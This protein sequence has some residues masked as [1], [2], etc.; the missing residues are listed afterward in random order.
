MSVDSETRQQLLELVYGAL[1]E[2]E[3]DRLRARIQDD[4]EVA[5]AYEEARSNAGLI[6]AAARISAPRVPLRRAERAGSSQLGSPAAAADSAPATRALPGR[7]GRHWT[8]MAYWTVGAASCVLLLLSLGGYLLHRQRLADIAA[9]H[10]R[11]MV[12]GPG[13]LQLG[14]EN[15]VDIS[16]T[17][18]TGQPMPAQ[19]ELALYSPDGEQLL[20]HKEKTDDDGKLTVT[21][22][23]EPP[24]PPSVRLEVLAVHRD[25]LQ[26]IDAQLATRPIDW[27]THVWTDRPRYRPGDTVFYRS[28]T[29]PR[30]TLRADRELPLAFE[31][32]APDGTVLPGSRNEGVTERGV[33]NGRFELPDSATPG[34]YRLYC[35]SLDD[36]APEARCGFRV[37][38]VRQPSLEAQIAFTQT[39]YRPGDTMVAQVAATD[40][41]GQPLAQQQLQVTV[42]VDRR[43]IDTQ[44]VTTDALGRTRIETHLPDEIGSGLGYVEIASPEASGEA[45]LP[46]RRR[47]PIELG[48][49]DVAFYPEGGNLVA[50]LENR[51]YFAAT[52][53]DGRPIEITGRVVDGEGNSIVGL[54]TT[55]HGRG[56]VTF[57]PRTGE[58]YRLEIDE[59]EHYRNSPK[60]P[61]VSSSQPALLTT[62]IGVFEPGK[63][64]AFNIRALETGLPLV[65]S[66]WCRGV[67]VGQS[68]LVSQEG[69]NSVVVELAD[70]AAGVVRLTV[71]DYSSSPPAPLSE[72]LI[73]RRPAR[74][75]QLDCEVPEAAVAGEALGLRVAALDEDGEGADAVFGVAVVDRGA[76]SHALK[77]PTL[78][79]AFLLPR[80]FD[81]S[82]LLD[83]TGMLLEESASSAVALDLLLGTSGWRRVEPAAAPSSQHL[84]AAS[85]STAT[86][87][88]RK[89]VASVQGETSPLVADNLGDIQAKYEK[90][91]ASYRHDRTRAFNA[92]IA[93]SLFGGVALIIFVTM[94]ALLNIATGPML[95]APA[96]TVSAVCTIIGVMLLGP[97]QRRFAGSPEVAFAPFEPAA[98]RSDFEELVASEAPAASDGASAEDAEPLA[99]EPADATFGEPIA[100]EAKARTAP[101]SRAN[102][103]MLQGAD[104]MAFS[105]AAPAAD[106]APREPEPQESA[107][108]RGQA[109]IAPGTADATGDQRAGNEGTAGTAAR[110]QQGAASGA[111]AEQRPAAAPAAREPMLEKAAKPRAE[112]E[113][114]DAPAG[115]ARDGAKDDLRRL[116]N[117]SR[118]VRRNE[119]ARPDKEL[120]L[121]GEIDRTLKQYRFAVRRYRYSQREK[122][123]D[124]APQTILWNPLLLPDD[125]A[126]AELSCQLPARAAQYRVFVDAHDSEGRLG[127]ARTDF[128]ARQ[129]F[130]LETSAPQAITRG[131]R[132]E[133]PVQLANLT[134][135]PLAADLTLQLDGKPL[136]LQG[137]ASR[138][139][140]IPANATV[141]E[142]FLLRS[143]QHRGTASLTI[144]AAAGRLSESVVA[145]MAV[146]DPGFP[147]S[148][149]TAGTLRGNQS[150]ELAVPGPWLA[151]TLQAQ[152]EVFPSTAAA[153]HAARRG[154]AARELDC[155][156]HEAVLACLD[157]MLISQLRR[158]DL[159]DPQWLA[160]AQQRLAGA[161]EK[162]ARFESPGHGWEPFGGDPADLVLTAFGVY[163]V[164]RLAEQLPNEMQSAQVMA[165]RAA[166]WLLGRHDGQGNFEPLA[167]PLGPAPPRPRRLVDAYLIW[168]LTETGHDE[169]ETALESLLAVTGDSDDP[170]FLALVAATAVNLGQKAQGKRL[171]DALAELQAVDGRVAGAS[172]SPFRSSG[173][174]LEIEA[175]ALAV[176][177]WQ[178]VP[179]YVDEVDRAVAWLNSQRKPDG[180]FGS[181]QATL[182]ALAA[183]SAGTVATPELEGRDVLARGEKD[184]VA[185][186]SIPPGA[187]RG[188]I[189]RGLEK[190]IAKGQNQLTLE[191]QGAA[192]PFVLSAVYRAAAPE[193]DDAPALQ[194][195]TSLENV[196]VAEDE[197]TTLTARVRNTSEQPLALSVAVIELPAGLKPQLDS[198]QALV[199]DGTIDAFNSTGHRIVCYWRGLEADRAIVLHVRLHATIPGQFVATPSRAFLYHRPGQVSWASPLE[200]RVTGNY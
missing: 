65:V 74:K 100:V 101:E 69:A 83:H 146:H 176:L 86:S 15:R 123:A 104:R 182:L 37:E 192:L 174:L 122:P 170:Y 177:A 127:A 185:K 19:V 140:E 90:S 153:I 76:W 136:R 191:T 51:V 92:L 171:M 55:H 155:F 8:Q 151:E 54:Q 23:A 17:R 84:A 168:A 64:L 112:V 198:L 82:P 41:D 137:Q 7:R 93:V 132:V 77:R 194:I 107:A 103:R 31:I 32:Q 131:D 87:T 6:A 128:F 157:A 180:C 45:Q 43:R 9:Q 166:R 13:E 36:T 56:S 143:Q 27:R 68:A 189:V 109:G 58:R 158:H 22:P 44:T 35:R 130:A 10:L 121:A 197:V 1:P 33:G 2:P 147:V 20:R 139:L 61:R 99:E 190:A 62:G 67:H 188:Y 148:R 96:L 111:R 105:P 150:V 11:L 21:I 5:A 134:S 49:I 59:P 102:R 24:L 28:L 184:V 108:A 113:A 187:H 14:L 46:V 126:T 38:T 89:L 172:V 3:A 133:L 169:L 52:L 4:P 79:E 181:A 42:L 12:T 156:E 119:A 29:L 154:L 138:Q 196:N 71:F 110:K 80:E 179:N 120:R 95:W 70:H 117:L 57:V 178:K 91:L 30:F 85:R 129:P 161:P 175:T 73:Y 115:P 145:P 66:A 78:P 118:R 195:T 47:I 88:D 125:D 18:V 183:V 26:R 98:D 97:E 16:T 48:R 25:K 72:R 60:L 167:E 144:A 164:D 50:D 34:V 142:Y 200:A 135:Q 81:D 114:A 199:D 149:S 163:A 173:T 160:A 63:P 39:A 193:P 159:I 124:A 75:L 94:I 162:L 165:D 53:P 186:Q 152:L 40:P 106:A 116:A 141:R